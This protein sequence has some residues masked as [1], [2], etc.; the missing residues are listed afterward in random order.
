MVDR[1]DRSTPRLPA[2]RVAG[3]EQA[4]DAELT[5]LK[6]GPADHAISSA[7]SGGD[8]LFAQACL[9]RGAALEIYLPA[10]RDAFVKTSVLPGG[11]CWLGIFD[12]VLAHARTAVHGSSSL[13]GGTSDGDIY[14]RCNVTMLERAFALGGDDVELVCLWDGGAGDGPGGTAHM[15][16]EVRRHGGRV[17][18]IDTRTLV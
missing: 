15:V 13:R 1:P 2:S 8:L 5:R 4:I 10:A 12:A 7:A 3:A 16:S 14:A 9:A 11:E 6:V 18:W 17:H